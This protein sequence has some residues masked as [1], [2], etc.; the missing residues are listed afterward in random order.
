[1]GGGEREGGRR[2]NGPPALTA[3]NPPQ[4][5]LCAV[6]ATVAPERIHVQSWLIV[7]VPS[8]VDVRD[9][10][11]TGAWAATE[12]DKAGMGRARLVFAVPR[13]EVVLKTL[14]FPKG[15]GSGE[16]ELAGMVRLQMTRQLTMAVEGTAIDY[17]PIG[18]EEGEKGSVTVMAAALP[19]ER[20]NGV[21]G[22]AEPL[23]SSG[24]I[25]AVGLGFPAVVRRGIA[26]SA[27]NVA[28]EWMYADVGK[29]FSEALG[30]QVWALNDSDAAAFAEARFGAG[31]PRNAQVA[32][33]YR[34]VRRPA[35]RPGR[36]A[37]VRAGWAARDGARRVG[38]QT[39]FSA[40]RNRR[41]GSALG[42][43]RCS[44][45]HDG[46]A[47]PGAPVTLINRSVP[48]TADLVGFLRVRRHSHLHARSAP[49]CGVSHGP[50]AYRVRVP[51]TLL[52]A[53]RG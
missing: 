12:L 34:G 46:R 16:A 2:G 18:E 29:V 35:S 11:A 4:N 23:L 24:D 5:R 33:G 14:R 37:R 51:I 39:G 38:G 9:G 3:L 31:R 20:M 27:V 28:R 1:M 47:C 10:A 26:L 44:P 8:E 22:I 32:A 53:G 36:S 42:R 40:G 7:K 52:S 13:G 17:A 6:H 19:G 30:R 15:E 45:S 41:T 43:G 50:R 48:M 49:Q 25:D 21:R